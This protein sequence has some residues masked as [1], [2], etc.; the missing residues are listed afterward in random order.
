M[1]PSSQARAAALAAAFSLVSVQQA[2]GH[3]GHSGG[4]FVHSFAHP[5]SGADHWL[6]MI[7][8][9]LLA[10]RLGKNALWTVPATFLVSMLVGGIAGATGIVWPGVEAGIV[11]SIL[12]LG[13][14]VAASFAIPTPFAI[15]LVGSFAVLH[16]YAHA[17]EMT[18]ASSANGYFAGF[19]FS[20]ALLLVLGTIAGRLLERRLLAVRFAGGAIAAT[21]VLMFFGVI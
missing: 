15:V 18:P 7:A 19:L 9:G 2:F 5:L 14:L 1:A 16:G 12:V 17:L 21:P 8:T 11:M 6:A 20:T 3:P 4:G 13:G 10:A